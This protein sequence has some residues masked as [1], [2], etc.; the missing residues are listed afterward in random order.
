[1]SITDSRESCEDRRKN[2]G[3]SGTL[4]DFNKQPGFPTYEY[5]EYFLI[6]PT[7]MSII[8]IW[9]TGACFYERKGHNTKS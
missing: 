4:G 3:N 5:I 8:V 6:V 1:M 7:V 9:C 2:K